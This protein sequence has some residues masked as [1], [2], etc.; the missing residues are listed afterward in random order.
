MPFWNSALSHCPT[1]RSHHPDP[2]QYLV[3]LPKPVTGD[4][5]CLNQSNTEFFLLKG[6]SQINMLPTCRTV[7]PK[8]VI[9]SDL[10]NKPETDLKH[11][12]WAPEQVFMP[13]ASL[14][15][16]NAAITFLSE[17]KAGYPTL[18]DIC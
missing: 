14:A 11:Y 8:H 12:K 15:K 10:S 13:D 1:E 5:E 18:N 3:F 4:L 17:E 16:I 6:I 2:S 7:L 9:I